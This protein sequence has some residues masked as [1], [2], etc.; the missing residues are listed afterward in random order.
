MP[1]GIGDPTPGNN[2]AS[3]TDNLAVLNTTKAL[4]ANADGDASGTVTQGDVLTFTVTV[5]NTGN[6]PLTNVVVSDSL[7]TPT[8]GTTP[9]A[10]V[11]VAGTCTL[12]GT[13]TV[14]ALDVTTGSIT[15]IGSGDS[16]ETGPDTA[17]VI[18][19]VVGSPALN[20]TKA[21]TANA[22][23]DASG[24]VTQG[25][26]LTFTVTVTNTGNVPLTNVVVSD[27][28]ITPTGGTTPCANVAVA[29]TCTLIGTY[30]VTALDVTTGSITNIGSGDS[31][32][33]GPDTATV[34]TP[35]VGSPA[36]NTTKALTANADGD[37]SGTV[38]QG[39][40]LTFTVTVTNTGNVP[41]TNVVVSDSLITPTGGTT[42]CANV[43]VAGT[44]T[45]IG[46]YTVTALDVTTGSITN[47]GSGDSN[48][49]GPDT[50]TVITPVVGSPA[51]NTTKALTANADGDASGT[52]TQG[53]VLTFTVTVTNTGNVPLTNVVVSDSLITPTGGTTPC[54]N[55][56]V[57]GTCTLIGTY[58][59]TA[60]DVTTGSITNIGS[61]DSNET[62]PDT[63]TVITPVVGSP[64]LN[65]T[66]ALTANADGDA[67][68]T[69][70]Q[71]DVLTFTVTVTN[72]GNV[73]LTNVV[74][75]DS[76]ITPT[77]G[78]TPC[79]N[80]AVA[81]TCTLIGTYTV[82]ALDV[83]TGSI[84]NIGSGDSN[85]TGPDTA[86]VITPVVG[87][88]ALNTTKALTANADGDASGT[89]TQ[90]DVLTF[91]VT[92]TNTGNVPLTNVVVSD[93]L[94]TPT[95]GTTPCANVAV[96]GTCTLI[97]TY[98]VTALDV[99][100]GSITNIGSGDS[101]ET[102]PDTA[103]V[104]T[105]VVGSP[106]LN[107]TK[108]LTANADGDASGTVTQG[109]VLTFTVTVTNTGNVPLTNVVVSDSL[110][111]PTGGTTPCANVAV[112]GTCTL[113]G[114]YTVTALDVTTG[115][116]TN[117]GSGDSNET[118]PDTATVITPVVGSPA[119]N[120]TKALT[121]NA[122]GDASGTVTQGDVLTFTVTVTNTGNVP[123]TNVVVSDSLITPTGGTTPCANVAVAGTCT[124]IGT[125][126]VTALDVTTGSITNIGSGDSDETGPDTATV[127]TPVVG[128]PALN[129]TKALTANAD[130]DASGTVTQGDVLTFT[131]TVT[132]TGNVPLTNVVVSDSLITP[133]GGT[134]PCA[135]VAVAATCTLIGTYTVTAADVTAG[136]ITN[137]GS[138]DSNETGPDTATVIT[139]VVG[140]PALNTTKALTANADGDASG[141]VTQY[142]GRRQSRAQHHQS[143]H[144]ECRRRCL[145]HRDP[146]RC[147]DL[148]RHRHQHRQC[149]ADQCRGER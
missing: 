45:L 57:A 89:V 14:T 26:V 88:P 9:C 145:R 91:T 97:G 92:V 114:T 46:T 118:G 51:L 146:G 116:I 43:A 24:T 122:D 82:T 20:T 62:G 40:V 41:L 142:A 38:T 64:A 10:N 27:S 11:A 93:S 58:T 59:V 77:G 111:T 134:T 86:T 76:L 39:D 125:Y 25:D 121:A 55:V 131:V 6:V 99:T 128:S 130:G 19:P 106:A 75:S 65:T 60:L 102:G 12:I 49:T 67:S 85:E 95:G 32:E 1:S 5:T 126:T 69:V 37:A 17:T 148:H 115:S 3:D 105:P 104:I 98:T 135:N 63:A 22:D 66:K 113:I 87:S 30:T 73:P 84:T 120:T 107:T 16:N 70:T 15:N 2:S 78:T 18:T 52:V 79:A 8:G 101:N 123:L 138:G 144:R 61:G 48:E 21:L 137:I 124:L 136:S 133:T 4:T 53:D 56:A 54:A 112:A 140:S 143:P 23:G 68:G 103:T 29:G 28:L 100:T 72:T 34:I 83:T 44:C 94:I 33:T 50:A 47:I 71:G 132:N 108:A 74:V 139:P 42:P 36:L 96:A 109:D 13:Y 117:I 7:I 110:I 31:N 127:I 129:T 147:A 149:A 119:L 80:V 35:V 90:G 141:T 81:G